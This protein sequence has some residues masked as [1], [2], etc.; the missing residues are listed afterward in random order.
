MAVSFNTTLRNSRLDLV[1]AAIDAGGASGPGTLHIYDGTR[2]AIDEAVGT[3]T[4][5]AVF[6]FSDPCASAADDGVLTFNAISDTT[7]LT[8]GSA[9]WARAFDS[10]SQIIADLSVSATGAG[11]DVTLNSVNVTTGDLLSVEVANLTEGNI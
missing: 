8:D 7:V 3:Q 4:L 6:S 11:G 5:L 9:T 2:P 10:D 1:A